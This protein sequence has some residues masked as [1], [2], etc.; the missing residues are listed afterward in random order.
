MIVD[1][2]T[3]LV[4]II[5]DGRLLAFNKNEQVVVDIGAGD[6]FKSKEA[7]R[8]D[9]GY[10]CYM[11]HKEVDRFWRSVTDEELES[12][13]GY[14]TRESIIALVQSRW[15]TGDREFATYVGEKCLE[16]SN[17]EGITSVIVGLA[18]A[19]IQKLESSFRKEG[20]NK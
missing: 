11:T 4:R 7:Y 1:E 9:A 20:N 8:R 6:Y 17:Q 16:V 12:P 10:P 2:H 13:L 15:P 3:G 5:E 14:E 19:D 18:D